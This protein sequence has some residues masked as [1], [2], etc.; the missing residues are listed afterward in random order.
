MVD[1]L[2]VDLLF[3]WHQ[4]IGNCEQFHDCFHWQLCGLIHLKERFNVT[5]P[6]ESKTIACLTAAFAALRPPS[7]HY[8]FASVQPS[9][10]V[11]LPPPST[12]SP[13]P[14]TIVSIS[15]SAP[16]SSYPTSPSHT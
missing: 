1:D 5:Q 13:R 6:Y 16:H 9:C 15:S 8:L 7:S 3:L 11:S 14:A 2:A 10:S 12:S 4:G